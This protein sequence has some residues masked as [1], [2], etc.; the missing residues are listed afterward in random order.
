MGWDRGRWLSVVQ[1]KKT[2]KCDVKFGAKFS[3]NSNERISLLVQISQK[4]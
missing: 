4:Y 2:M 3:V 1:L